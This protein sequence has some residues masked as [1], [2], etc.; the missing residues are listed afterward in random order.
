MAVAS[1]PSVLDPSVSLCSGPVPYKEALQM[2]WLLLTT[3][4][5]MD[6]RQSDGSEDAARL[7]RPVTFQTSKGRNPLAAAYARG[8]GVTA[9]I[10]EY[11]K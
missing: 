3:V 2:L 9:R 11:L 1:C 4:L 6:P 8:G 7:T 10:G 5:G